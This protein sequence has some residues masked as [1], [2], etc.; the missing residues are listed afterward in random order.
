MS[1]TLGQQFTQR[2]LP[3]GHTGRGIHIGQRP[4]PGMEPGLH[5]VESPKG[6]SG[7]FYASEGAGDPYAEEDGIVGSERKHIATSSL[8]GAL[9]LVHQVARPEDDE[10][11]EDVHYGTP[12]R[13]EVP[14]SHLVA[15]QH[16]TDTTRLNELWHHPE[17]SG[18][19]GNMPW[20]EPEY[21]GV[22]SVVRTVNPAQF[23]ILDGNHRLTVA[24]HQNQ[25]FQPVD[26][27]TPKEGPMHPKPPYR[28]GEPTP[29]MQVPHTGSFNPYPALAAAPAW[30]GK[31]RS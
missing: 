12:V 10:H 3:L 25:L 22:P 13:Q 21:K 2:Q 5:I 26:V 14:I 31:N 6:P 28:E 20:H 17:T 8:P 11:Y 16:I 29:Q 9:P 4:E 30:K 19:W 15:E 24:A 7:P 23:H 18:R 27:Y 1:E